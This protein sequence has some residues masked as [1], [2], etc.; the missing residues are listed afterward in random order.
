MLALLSVWSGLLAFLVAVAML[1]WRPLFHDITIPIALYTAIFSLTCAG[2]TLWALRREYHDV[3]GVDARRTQ[4][5]VGCGL[6]LAAITIT[7]ALIHFAEVV[8]RGG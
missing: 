8:P 5:F 4:C 3:E 2:V 6:A 1:L 7:Y